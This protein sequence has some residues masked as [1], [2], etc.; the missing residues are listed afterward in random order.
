MLHASKLKYF[1]KKEKKK[2]ILSAYLRNKRA[3]TT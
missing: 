2:K 3:I 1:K